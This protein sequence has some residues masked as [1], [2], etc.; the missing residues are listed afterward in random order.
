VK[1][2]SSRWLLAAVLVLLAGTGLYLYF[3][4]NQPKVLEG[5]ELPPKNAYPLLVQIGAQVKLPPRNAED[6]DPVSLTRLIQDNS[7]S[8]ELTLQAM[9]LPSVV[10]SAHSE[11]L[12]D[13]SVDEHESLRALSRLL[14]LRAEWLQM[15]NQTAAAAHAYVDLV[16]FGD[17]ISHGGPMLHHLNRIAIQRPAFAALKGLAPALSVGEL[18]L[19]C[20]KLEELS[21]GME[22]LERVL[23]NES[24]FFKNSA[25]EREY[26][27]LERRSLKIRLKATDERFAKKF[28]EV[29]AERALLLVGLALKSFE[30]EH[31]TLPP[32]LQILTESQLKNLP[33]DPFAPGR[34]FRYRADLRT[35]WSVGENGKDDAGALDDIPWRIPN[36]S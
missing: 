27:I 18:R 30:G 29:E 9:R 17:A 15:T 24:R 22:S 21:P 35:I 32:A 6:K 31:G 36:K 7:K 16:Q 23:E 13:K 25:L 14:K 1:L 8:I 5:P 4:P 20:R 34:A 33:T 19:V 2:G 26:N 10:N 11:S 3:R 12:L 28:Q